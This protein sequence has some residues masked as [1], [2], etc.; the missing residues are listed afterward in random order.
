MVK[1]S[2]HMRGIIEKRKEEIE[3]DKTQQANTMSFVASGISLAC[4]FYQLRDNLSK[5]TDEINNI[6]LAFG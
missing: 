1:M 4:I 6:H 5:K 3:Q 2:A